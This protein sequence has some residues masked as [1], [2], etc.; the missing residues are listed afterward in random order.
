M[1]FRKSI[2]FGLAALLSAWVLL[3]SLATVSPDLH[4]WLHH[5]EE[6]TC[7]GH[8]HD[9]HSGAETEDPLHPD[10]ICAVTLF[11][12]GVDCEVGATLP[13]ATFLPIG[14]IDVP[15]LETPLVVRRS[16]LHARAPPVAI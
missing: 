14:K 4:N 5:H 10:H 9:E 16:V 15:D 8:C 1:K 13:N 6:D 7:E 3:L 11:A 2:R 12:G